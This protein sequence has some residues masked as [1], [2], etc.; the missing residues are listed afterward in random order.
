M[1]RS[2]LKQIICMAAKQVYPI[3]VIQH[4]QG[5][6]CPHHVELK[7]WQSAAPAAG[8]AT[9]AG[10]AA[11]AASSRGLQQHPS[12]PADHTLGLPLTDWLT[13]KSDS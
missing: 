10:G 1:T 5:H 2:L 3:Y 7:D 12:V 13:G 4:K 11:G 9:A 8:A 6:H